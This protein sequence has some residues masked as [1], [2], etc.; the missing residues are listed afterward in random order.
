[1]DIY[2]LRDNQQFGPYSESEFLKYLEE[3][4]II[5]TDLAWAAEWGDEWLAVTEAEKRVRQVIDAQ[6]TQNKPEGNGKAVLPAEEM[7]ASQKDIGEGA[8]I[9]ATNAKDKI[10]ISKSNKL[11]IGIAVPVLLLAVLGIS[12]IQNRGKDIVGTWD[13]GEMGVATFEKDGS[14]LTTTQVSDVAITAIARGIYEFKKDTITTKHKTF[15]MQPNNNDMKF[16]LTKTGRL[17]AHPSDS[18]ATY[19]FSFENDALDLTLLDGQVKGKRAYAI[20]KTFN[21]KMAGYSPNSDPVVASSQYPTNNLASDNKETGSSSNSGSR[22]NSYTSPQDNL[23]RGQRIVRHLEASSN[24]SCRA[25]GNSMKA[26]VEAGR[27][28]AIGRFVS[29]AKRQGCFD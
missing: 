29:D 4:S 22:S 9:L 20:G 14:F 6:Q 3:Q 13:C 10:A 2:I 21:C 5:A 1:M 26:L 15:E 25:I 23:T 12:A 27:E 19:K 28:D 7:V 8:S 11:K 24:F 16:F 18:W 17:G